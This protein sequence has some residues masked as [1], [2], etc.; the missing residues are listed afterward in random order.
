MGW[1]GW[2]GGKTKSKWGKFLR[3]ASRKTKRMEERWEKRIGKA[4][5]IELELKLQEIALA[6]R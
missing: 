2:V 5:R 1:A 6:P 4:N 3:G